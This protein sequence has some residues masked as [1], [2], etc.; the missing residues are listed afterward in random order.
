M[1]EA[2]N[3]STR[4]LNT[5]QLEAVQ[6]IEGP[7][8]IV[9]GPGSGKTRVITHRIAYLHQSGVYPNKIAAVTFTNRAAKEMRNR[10]ERLMG[11][12][13]Q[14]LSAGTF[15]SFSA[16][17]LRRDGQTIG[18]PRDFVIVDDDDQ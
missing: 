8:L 6:H 11:D 18:I 14:D 1:D 12:T 15:H 9:A 4:G 17:I 7:L 10:L 16:M 2:L 5:A 13:S 3:D